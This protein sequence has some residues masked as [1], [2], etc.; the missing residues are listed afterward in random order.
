MKITTD[1]I[2]ETIIKVRELLK[3]QTVNNFNT[4]YLPTTYRGEL[5]R[6]KYR[7]KGRPRWSDYKRE[8]TLELLKSIKSK[9]NK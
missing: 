4:M 2:D 7:G 1:N 6:S 3:S 8:D 9:S 5:D